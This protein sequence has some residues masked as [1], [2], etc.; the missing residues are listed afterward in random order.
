MA[1]SDSGP[2]L[3][4]WWAGRPLATVVDPL[5]VVTRETLAPS[6]LLK[7][8]SIDQ[9]E[10]RRQPLQNWLFSLLR[11]SRRP[12]SAVLWTALVDEMAKRKAWE[13]ALD[14]A[15]SPFV[16]L[17]RK[18]AAEKAAAAVGARFANVG[19]YASPQFY[20]RAVAGVLD[21]SALER[22]LRLLRY[23]YVRISPLSLLEHVIRSA[24]A[25][26]RRRAIEQ[27]AAASAYLRAILCKRWLSE[28]DTPG[29]AV[30]THPMI[31]RGPNTCR[32]IRSYRPAGPT[33]A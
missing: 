13:I 16:V 1:Y 30:V 26:F 33:R 25:D 27:E 18:A 4:P 15:L 8:L 6:P 28:A 24:Q 10:A 14:D 20:R 7:S 12:A 32:S 22:L 2:T 17:K 19:T 21:E 23:V 31:T 3:S 11:G 29:R 9:R 5:M